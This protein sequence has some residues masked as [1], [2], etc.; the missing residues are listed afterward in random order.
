[1]YYKWLTTVGRS[2]YTSWYWPLP[3]EDG[4]SE[5]TP[6]VERLELC[7]SGYH[8]SELR[9]LIDHTNSIYDLACYE[10]EYDGDV[11]IGDDKVTGHRARLIRKVGE[12]NARKWRLFA[13]DCAERVLHIYENE[14]P[15]DK[16][17]RDTIEVARRYA[18]G[19]ATEGEL[20][21][22]YDAAWEAW[23]A[24]GAIMLAANDAASAAWDANDTHYGVI[25]DAAWAAASAA[26]N[27]A[28]DAA[29]AARWDVRAVRSA[30]KATERE[31]QALCLLE[32]LVS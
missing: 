19:E 22:A 13:C 16:R 4:P 32:Y 17:P 18:N 8:A 31:W 1:M 30:A 7:D 23:A 25:N 9:Y 11:L 26:Y 2:P 24:S 29:W 6:Y 5:W 28:W 21:A 10:L 20:S 15:D 12:M 14:H 27:A 3:A